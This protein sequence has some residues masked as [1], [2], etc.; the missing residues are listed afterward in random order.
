MKK[1]FFGLGISLVC[2]TGCSTNEKEFVSTSE[3]NSS[4]TLVQYETIAANLEAPWAINKL[5]D[6]F[7]ITERTGHI[8][9][10]EQG[11]VTRQEVKLEKMLSTASEAGLLGLVLAPDFEQSNEAYAYYTYENGSDQFNRIVL[12]FLENNKW[13]EQSVLLD[14]IPSGTYHHGGRV[15]I[16]PDQKLYATAGDASN[17]QTA[18]DLSTLGGKILRLNLDGSI[19]DDNPFP[20]SYVYSYGHRNP[21]GITWSPDGTMYASEHGQSANDEINKIEAGQNYGW[22]SIEGEQT[23]EGFISPLFT[24]GS[25]HTWAPSGMAFFN[26][27]LYVAALRGTAVLEFDLQ[28]KEV[29]EI[30]NNMGRIRDVWIEDHTLYWITNN[31]D[32]RGTPGEK[33]DQL[34]KLEL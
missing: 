1:L 8:V 26:N 14:G 34:Y 19:P 16:G 5:G 22:P 4:Q 2:L 20:N 28:T 27:K 23:Q 7:Y 17:P 29:K 18:Q 25:E 10:V 24:S 31:T 21:Q 9:K 33:D 15:K 11:E 30:V 32:G 13:R 6:V 12:L 3:R